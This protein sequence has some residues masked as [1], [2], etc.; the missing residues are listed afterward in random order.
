M[1]V[2]FTSMLFTDAVLSSVRVPPGKQVPTTARGA[3]L[4]PIMTH[5][6][7]SSLVIVR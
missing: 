3:H 4:P 7:I 6:V 5:L 1:P 2:P